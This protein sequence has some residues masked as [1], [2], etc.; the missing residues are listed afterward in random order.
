MPVVVSLFS[1]AGGLD[2]GFR[3]AGYRIGCCVELESWACDTLR[4]NHPDTPVMGPPQHSGDIKGIFAGDICD[5]AALEKSEVD[6]LIGGPPCQP[7]SQAA[8]QRFVKGDERFKRQGFNDLLKGTLLFDFTRL[9]L[10]F[11]PRVFVIENVPGLMEMDGREQLS[12]T[13]RELHAAGYYTSPLETIDAANYGV[14]QRRERLI[15]WGSKT[16]EKPTLPQPT[17]AEKKNLF[18]RP[19]NTVVQALVGMPFNLA[20]HRTRKHTPALIARYKNLEFGQRD[21][22]GRVDRLDPLKPSKT[23]IAGGTKGGGRSHLHPF[24]ARTL[25]VR[26]CARLQ[27]FDDSYIFKGK[28][29]R[30]FT[31]VGNAVPPLLSE[32]LA[33]HIKFQEFGLGVQEP[34][35]YGQYLNHEVDL[36]LLEERLFQ[37]SRLAIP[38]WMYHSHAVVG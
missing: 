7:F 23:V 15:I 24:V 19:H 25:T 8:S 33:R 6:V 28:M 30:Q 2:A 17:H 11:Q 16:V 31:Q 13:L 4:Y 5:F 26:E 32:H 1:G 22:L 12:Q 35:H 20:N 37:E 21:K 18:H 34:L 10:E 36:K 3:A 29:A 9:I 38:E 14:P 27:T